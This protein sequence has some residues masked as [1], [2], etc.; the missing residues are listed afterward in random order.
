MSFSFE[1]IILFIASSILSPLILKG[2]VYVLRTFHCLDRPHLYK[3]EAG[4]TPVPYGAGIS[5]FLTIL[6]FVPILYF[7]LDFTAILEHRL[8]IMIILGA[9]IAIISFLDDMETIGRSWIRIPPILR[10]MMQIAV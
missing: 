6:A 1:I 2:I 4:R 10:L 7:I 9:F 8:H 5:I 3:S